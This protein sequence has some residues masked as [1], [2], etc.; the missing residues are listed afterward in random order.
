MRLR[1]PSG[2]VACDGP[3]ESVVIGVECFSVAFVCDVQNGHRP[4]NILPHHSRPVVRKVP[5]QVPSPTS[6]Q[7]LQKALDRPI[8]IVLLTAPSLRSDNPPS[9]GN[10]SKALRWRGPRIAEHGEKHHG[11]GWLLSYCSNCRYVIGSNC[12]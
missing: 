3:V 9:F 6:S 1:Q 5:H 12:V 4:P 2:A 11:T 8:A 7:H 10:L